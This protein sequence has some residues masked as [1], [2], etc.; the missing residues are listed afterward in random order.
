MI[1]RIRFLDFRQDWR[2][3]CLWPKIGDMAATLP[4][5]AL[6]TPPSRP[7]SPREEAGVFR[8]LRRKL[9]VS[10]FRELVTTRRLWLTAL[11]VLTA[12]FWIGL[13]IIFSQGF[14]FLHSAL[15]HPATRALTVQAVYN[16][17]FLALT[18]MLLVSSGI[19]LYGALYR[20]DEVTFLLTA[21]VRAERIVLYKLQEAIFFSCW[22]FALLGTPMLIAYGVANG[23]P[24]YYYALL[25]PFMAAFV[26]IPTSLGA[27]A[28]LFIVYFLPKLRFHALAVVG[29]LMIA[30][31]VYAGWR[32]FGQAAHQTMT[33][34]WF[35]DVLARLQFTQQRILPSWWLSSGL[36]EAAHPAPNSG[37][38]ASWLESL[39]F[40]AVLT[41]NGLL[42]QLATAAVAAR[43]YRASYSGLRAVSSGRRRRGVSWFDRAAGIIFWPL[44]RLMRLFIVND[45]RLFRRDPV[46]WSQ[47]LIF[48]GLLSFYF[49]NIRRF[50]YNDALAGW[51]TLI[52]FLNLG[53]VGLILS[54]YTTRFILPSISLE[55]RRFW[56]LGTLPISRDVVLWSKFWFSF[57]GTLAPCSALILL[58][59][60]MLE[61]TAR[62][63]AVAWLH[64]LTCVMLCA[65][66]S[67]LAV[68]VGARLPNLREPN[69]SKIAAG[70]GGTLCLVISTVYI[71][72]VV[73]LTAVP[74]Y[75]WIEGGYFMSREPSFWKRWF[76]WGTS[77]SVAA[78]ALAT[79][80]LG[81]AA[82]YV[83]L[84]I[85]FRAFRRWEF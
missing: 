44:P 65:G 39:L 41:A 77:G 40:L 71:I 4:I 19:I 34:E 84:R 42:L 74:C 47:F 73:M 25:F 10:L 11:V 6:A 13:Y 49:I 20:S 68:G 55:G 76:G 35:Q 16:V 9:L 70:F 63:P 59:D 12:I 36:L 57:L 46:Q 7:L 48:F 3:A 80:L 27:A 52:G 24:W 18:A 67:A 54:T 61:T 72:G 64:Q 33:P 15:P 31:G 38:R 22:G 75:F 58:S 85:G 66:L 37:G 2:S 8:R 1:N 50:N 83:P 62:A 23:S 43:I 69:P 17:F 30:A 51:M 53:V 45:L 21:P 5:D 82:T 56:V 81:A 79:L 60:V 78:G 29:A 32:T 26:L 28:C 14:S